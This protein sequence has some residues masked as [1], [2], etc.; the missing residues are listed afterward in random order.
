MA[1]AVLPEPLQLVRLSRYLEGPASLQKTMMAWRRLGWLGLW[2]AD[3]D[4]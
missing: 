4:Q 1:M 2:R 3:C